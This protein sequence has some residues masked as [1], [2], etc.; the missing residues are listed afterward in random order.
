MAKYKNLDEGLIDKFIDKI[1]GGIAKRQ[2]T[3]YI[4]KISK[5]DPKLG[6]HLAIAQ[7]AGETT[8]KYLKTLSKAERDAFEAEWEAL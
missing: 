2:A 6:K 1:F 7:K 5:Q 4:K 8:K 3:S